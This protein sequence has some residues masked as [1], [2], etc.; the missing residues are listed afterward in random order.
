VWP[1]YHAAK[2]GYSHGGKVCVSAPKTMMLE[3]ALVCVGVSA[4]E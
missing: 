4:T 3:D 1:D 2:L